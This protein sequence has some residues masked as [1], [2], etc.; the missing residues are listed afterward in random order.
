MAKLMTER[1]EMKV[2]RLIRYIL[3]DVGGQGLR[4]VVCEVRLCWSRC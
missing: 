1:I 4:G 3:A 2:V